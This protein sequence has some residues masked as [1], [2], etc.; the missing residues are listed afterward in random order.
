MPL[1]ISSWFSPT[2]KA[3]PI[4]GRAGAPAASP[5]AIPIRHPEPRKILSSLCAPCRKAIPWISN[6]VCRIC[7]RAERCEDCT[8]RQQRNYTVSRCAVRYDYLMKDWLALYKYRG[9]EGLESILAAMLAFAYERLCEYSPQSHSFAAITSVPL[10][11][12]RLQDRGFNQAERLALQLSRWYGLSYR[13]ML[14]RLRH[15]EKQSLKTRR[16]RVV[17]MRGNFSAVSSELFSHSSTLPL[18]PAAPTAA[19]T[20]PR[21]ILVDDIYTT[22][23]TLEECA[24]V[25]RQSA[26]PEALP[27][28]Y[29]LLWARS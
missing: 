29:G 24:R 11:P 7:G 8:R 1:N 22:G 23:S 25:L 17:D 18:S 12:E 6:P 5:I 2:T 21:I 16:S 19:S 13:P 15:T 26:I 9:N 28:I 10:A 20:T 4:C 3:C 14:L 27:E